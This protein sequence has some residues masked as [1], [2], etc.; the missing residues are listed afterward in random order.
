MVW[1]ACFLAVC[2]AASGFSYATCYDQA[3]DYYGVSPD[4][5]R[6]IATVESNQDPRAVNVNRD[7]SRDIGLMQINELWLPKLSRMGI[8]EDD[9]WDACVSTFVGAWVLVQNVAHYGPSWEAVGAY[10]A[11]KRETA[12]A[13]ANRARYIERVKEA[14]ANLV[15]HATTTRVAGGNG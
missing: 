3:G 6:A 9:L 2:L 12:A 5:L 15:G 4:L 11:G 8:S 14:L 13:R 7:G 1:R 10:N